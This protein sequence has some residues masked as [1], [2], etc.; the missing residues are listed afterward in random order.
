MKSAE[1]DSVLIIGCGWVGTKLATTL[2]SQN[3][4]VFGTTRSAEKASSLRSFYIYGL[5]Y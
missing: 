1:L 2:I 3:I 5:I 4:N